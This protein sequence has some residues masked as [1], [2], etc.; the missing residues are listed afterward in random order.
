MHIAVATTYAMTD[1][2]VHLFAS[3]LLSILI[4]VGCRSEERDGSVSDIEPVVIEDIELFI[5]FDEGDLAAPVSV[6]LVGHDEIG[7]ADAG[8]NQ[9][10]VFDTDGDVVRRFGTEGEGPGEFASAI[11]LQKFGD[12]LYVVDEGLQ[13]I[14]RFTH[15]GEFVERYVYDSEPHSRSVS[16]AGGKRYYAASNG[17]QNSLIKRVDA[18]ADSVFYFG[19]AMGAGYVRGDLEDERRALSQ[20]EVPTLHVNRVTMDYRDDHLYVFLDAHSRLQKYTADGRVLW[21]TEID[22]PINEMIFDDVVQRARDAPTAAVPVFR[23]IVSMTVANGETFL[24]WYPVEGQPRRMVK[25]DENGAVDIIYHLPE[26]EP[27]YSDIAIDPRSN[28]LYL[29]APEMGQIYRARLPS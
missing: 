20:G 6:E 3:V 7:V 5:D 16:A 8:T 1:Q 4:L 9:I 27:L 22:L 2:H 21:D 24:L 14:N 10:T 19:A 11:R 28:L 17:E 25:V 18:E 15:S 23:Y 29:T 12:H 13:R 26:D